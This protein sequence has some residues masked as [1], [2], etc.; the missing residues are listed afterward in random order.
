MTEGKKKNEWLEWIKAILIALVLVWVVKMFLFEPIVVDGPSMQPTLHDRDHMIVNKIGYRIGEPSR[1]DIVVFHASD[2]KDFIKRVIGLPGE[3]V[4]YKD[5]QLYINDK[6][7]KEPF[8]DKFK[9]EDIQT[10]DFN[11]EDLPGGYEKIPEGYV[12]VLGDNRT[13]STDS[14]IIGLIPMDK[15]VGKTSVIYWPISRMEMLGE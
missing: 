7:K 4:S 6:P 8:F 12:L 15:I 5:N 2:K 11:L 14:R 9:D 10:N 1:F 13:N 3:H